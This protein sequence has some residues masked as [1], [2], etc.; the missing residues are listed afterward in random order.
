[1][2]I[3]HQQLNNLSDFIQ[4]FS[5]LLETVYKGVLD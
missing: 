5:S 1:M 2:N 4:V 3:H